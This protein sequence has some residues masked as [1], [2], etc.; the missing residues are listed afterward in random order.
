MKVISIEVEI[1]GESVKLT[2]DEAKALY[3]SLD[4]IFSYGG[5]PEL[6]YTQ[7]PYT[8]PCG[9]EGMGNGGIGIGVGSWA[10]ANE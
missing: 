2:L 9:A 6:S 5:K 3:R 7:L 8:I 1:K 4:G 10:G